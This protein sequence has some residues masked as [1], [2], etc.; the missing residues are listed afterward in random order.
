MQQHE[1]RERTG[2]AEREPPSPFAAVDFERTPFTVAWEVTRACALACVHCRAM[3]QPQRSPQEL[4]LDECL[5]VVDQVAE[6]GGPILVITGGDPFMRPDLW[7][8]VAYARSR[9]L[10]VAISPSAT[11]LV[12]R[13]ALERCVEHGVARLHLSL[14]GPDAALHDAFRGVPGSF[15]RTMEILDDARAAGLSVQIGTTAN[16]LNLAALP[17]IAERVEAAGA[18]MWSVFMLVPTGRGRLDD[19]I[20]AEEHERVFHWLC[21]LAEDA[22]FD[23]RTT[24]GMHFRRVVIQRRLAAGQS[25]DSRASLNRSGHTNGMVRAAKGVNDGRGFAFIDHLGNVCPSGFL[26]VPAGNVRTSTLADVYRDSPLFRALRDTERLRGR[27]GRCEYRVVCGGSRARAYAVTGDM[28]A[29]DP[30][31]VYEPAVHGG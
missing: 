2:Q 16:R 28:F 31:C 4:T 14:D 27:C 12:T 18:A 19:M 17:R 25:A 10:R 30:S 11:R 21:D 23:V 6:I 29:E 3:A 5:R 26:Q 9:G 22:P 24:A 7:E 8:I 15:L 13:E 1:R 20:S